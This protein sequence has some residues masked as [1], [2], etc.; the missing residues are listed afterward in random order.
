L[1]IKVVSQG[2]VQ[3][4]RGSLFRQRNE[5]TPPASR[6]AA[7]AITAPAKLDPQKNKDLRNRNFSGGKNLDETS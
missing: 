2:Q 1:V 5:E 6:S 7:Y 3:Q 4:P